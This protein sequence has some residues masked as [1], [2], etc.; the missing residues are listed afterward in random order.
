MVIG[1]MLF[2]YMMNYNNKLVCNH[3]RSYV[4]DGYPLLFLIQ[5]E[6]FKYLYVFSCGA[7][8][9]SFNLYYFHCCMNGLYYLMRVLQQGKN[10]RSSHCISAYM[11]L[12]MMY[13]YHLLSSMI[14][15]IKIIVNENN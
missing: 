5:I 11:I 1:S 3:Y 2:E 9:V 15:K 12:I 8:S 6:I 14:A 13:N 4:R 7:V 10:V